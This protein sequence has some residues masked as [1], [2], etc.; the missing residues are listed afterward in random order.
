MTLDSISPRRRKWYE[1]AK[2]ETAI[3]CA[4]VVLTLLFTYPKARLL[5]NGVANSGDPLLNAWILAWDVH[6]L[7]GDVADFFD[8]NI[9]YPHPNTLAY[10]ESQLANALLAMPVLLIFRNPILAHNC[11]F[12][13]SFAASGFSMYLLVKHLTGGS[14]LA[15][16]VSGIIFAFCPYKIAHFTQLQMLSTQWMPFA[17]LFL[18]KALCGQRWRD[19]F[20]FTLFFNLQAL[21]SYYYALFFGVAVGIL[22]LFYVVTGGR[23]IWS[24]KL[25]L[26]L[27]CSS[28]LTLLINVPLA[29]PYIELSRMGFVRSRETTLLFQAALTDYLTTTPGNW[30]YGS[31]TAPLRGRYWSEHT[32]FPGIL[33]VTLT[34]LGTGGIFTR[35]SPSVADKKDFSN[36]SPQVN[37]VLVYACVLVIAVILAMGTVWSLPGTSVHLSLPF[38]C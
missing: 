24:W 2:G 5:T 30:L 18:D 12:L 21:S 6:K 10:S 27:T 8:A 38:G 9:F 23:R 37:V 25:I 26:Q 33:A 3:L 13:F 7:T 1:N 28:A 15:G 17:L 19:F 31:L 4:F 34:L 29:M 11:V 35:P 14:R 36:G 16:V 20:L 32:F 22:L